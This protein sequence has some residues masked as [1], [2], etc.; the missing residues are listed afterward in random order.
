MSNIVS[1]DFGGTLTNDLYNNDVS[2]SVEL[3]LACANFFQGSK[4][5]IVILKQIVLN[6]VSTVD[7]TSGVDHISGPES[8]FL[9][10]GQ[11]N[12]LLTGP[13]SNSH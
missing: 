9:Y 10:D 8:R 4:K 12:V 6:T 13:S 5:K 3:I 11:V 1:Y 2:K 7:A